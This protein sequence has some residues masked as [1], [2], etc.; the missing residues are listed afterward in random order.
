MFGLISQKPQKVNNI[1]PLHHIFALVKAG[2]RIWIVE[3]I[4][5]CPIVPIEFAHE[6]FN[7]LQRFT[8]VNSDGTYY[9][10]T[11]WKKEKIKGQ[12]RLKKYE[13]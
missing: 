1:N 6:I 8:I 9:D 12:L 11:G 2:G 10:Y 5:A 13:E 3:G 4:K 7:N